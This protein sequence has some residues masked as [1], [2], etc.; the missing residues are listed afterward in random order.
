MSDGTTTT[1]A[2]LP[3]DVVCRAGGAQRDLYGRVR[4]FMASEFAQ[5][6]PLTRKTESR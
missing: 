4:A 1:P 3:H 5:I 2:L 6:T